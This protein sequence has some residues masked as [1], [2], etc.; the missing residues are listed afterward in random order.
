MAIDPKLLDP[1]YWAS[2]P[3]VKGTLP[4]YGGAGSG[5]IT[6]FPSEFQD[7][8]IQ[9][10]LSLAQGQQRGLLGGQFQKF[11]A[12]YI[13]NAVARTPDDFGYYTHPLLA[14]TDYFKFSADDPTFRSL[15]PS[16]Q[17]YL[18]STL[19]F[20]PFTAT[21]FDPAPII[22]SF[23]PDDFSIINQSAEPFR[24][25]DRL[26]T[27]ELL[28][29]ASAGDIKIQAGKSGGLFGSL[30]SAIPGVLGTIAG[31]PIGGAIGGAISGGLTG[32]KKGALLGGLTGGLSG[33]G[34]VG[35]LL[36]NTS[37]GS[38]V[39]NS[40]SSGLSSIANSNLNPFNY[41]SGGIQ[42]LFGVNPITTGI[43]SAL[44]LGGPGAL[45]GGLVG[46]KEGALYGG[47]AGAGLGLGLDYAPGGNLGNLFGNLLG[48]GG[49]GAGGTAG[50]AGGVL[51]GL[52]GGGGLGNLG[53]LLAGGI[54]LALLTNEAN[55]ATQTPTSS[56][57]P[58]SSVSDGM[59]ILDPA[60]RSTFV[61]NIDIT[62]SL[63]D[64]ARGNQGAFIQARVNPLEAQIARQRGDLEQSIGLRGLSGSSFGDQAM[65][66]FGLDTERA[67]GDARAQA[68]QEALGFESNLNQLLSQG[69]SQ[70]LAQEL[71][72]LGL[73]DQNISRLLER[74]KLRTDL[75]GRAASQFGS[76]LGG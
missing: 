51:S 2:L 29:R 53:G 76:L 36:K 66:S 46:G 13:K 4:S 37:M 55:K 52:L 59:T 41:L 75:F 11:D 21:S 47:L 3:I 7:A 28:R 35:G 49:G 45:L 72:A 63:I 27:N 32:G 33:A 67:L 65:R 64:R 20:K 39:M 62:R 24:Q 15:S 23:S 68:T 12:D 26:Y 18:S 40:I 34:G 31:G 19:S 6:A 57:T 61:D 73:S 16:A 48:P 5:Y 9:N 56:R 71:G 50:G 60:I 43:G 42:G 74:A 22:S 44:S 25:A 58:F 1:G 54:P 10:L 8:Q 69:G 30:M 70:L 38:G 17:S 14:L